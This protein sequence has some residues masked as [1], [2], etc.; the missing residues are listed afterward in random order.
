MLLQKELPLKVKA[1]FKKSSSKKPHRKKHF[2]RGQNHETLII[3]IIEIK[4]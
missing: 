1:A 3:E 4:K 2:Q